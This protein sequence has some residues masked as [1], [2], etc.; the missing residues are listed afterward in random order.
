MRLPGPLWRT[1]TTP[2]LAPAIEPLRALAAEAVRTGSVT[3]PEPHPDAELLAL[4]AQVLELTAEHDSIFEAAR[5]IPGL[6]ASLWP[7]EKEATS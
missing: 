5:K 7:P 3:E 2:D 1:N 6:R 4:C